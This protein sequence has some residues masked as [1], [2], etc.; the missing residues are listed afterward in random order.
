[1]AKLKVKLHD[2]EGYSIRK[3]TCPSYFKELQAD[4][5]YKGVQ[6]GHMGILD[7]S[8]LKKIDWSYPISALEINVEPIIEDFYKF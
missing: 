1:M 8:I 4:I 5:Y 7:P 2:T 6:I 3:G